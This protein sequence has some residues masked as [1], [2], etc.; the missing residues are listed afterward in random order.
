MCRSVSSGAAQ[1]SNLP[2]VGLPRLTG[3]EDRLGHRALPLRR[4]P[5]VASISSAAGAPVASRAA[6]GAGPA[7][8]GAGWVTG[9]DAPVDAGAAVGSRAPIAARAA[10]EQP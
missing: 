9:D 3:F 6:V 10:P 8:D 5:S 7:L 1:E 2:S 4:Q